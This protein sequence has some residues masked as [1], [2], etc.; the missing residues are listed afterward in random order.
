MDLL[1][2]NR[3]TL[4]V[5]QNHTKQYYKIDKNKKYNKVYFIPSS[6]PSHFTLISLSIFVF[7]Q[8]KEKW[9]PFTEK[10]ILGLSLLSLSSHSVALLSVSLPLLKTNLI[11]YGLSISFFWFQTFNRTTG[12]DFILYISILAYRFLDFCF[13][14]SLSISISGF[15]FRF[16]VAQQV[17]QVKQVSISA[18]FDFDFS[19]TG[20]DFDFD[21]CQV[22]ISA[23]RLTF[24]CDFV[25]CILII[26]FIWL[27]H[28]D[29]FL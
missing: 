22:L 11:D 16:L 14:F 21:F 29:H 3:K 27:L 12:F 17:K 25:Y 23:Y 5:F 20:F 1:G 6:F 10:I 19:T 7:P 4:P 2:F 9:W 28:S 24:D 15:L 8:Y 18:P 26:F 13:D